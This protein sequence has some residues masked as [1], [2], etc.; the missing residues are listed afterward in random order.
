MISYALAGSQAYGDMLGLSPSILIAPFVAILALLVT[1]FD[2]ILQTVI[3]VMTFVKGSLL[4]VMVAI[5][6]VVGYQVNN[7][8]SDDWLYSGQPFLIGTVALG[9]AVNLL[10]VVYCKIKFTREDMVKFLWAVTLGLLVVF[11][12]NI[13][14]AFY[15]LRIVPQRGEGNTLQEAQEKG[16][17]STIPLV[18]IIRDEHKKYLWA[19]IIVNIFIMVSITVSFITMGTGLKH[20]I[21][22]YIKSWTSKM[23]RVAA[24]PSSATA[25]DCSTKAWLFFSPYCSVRVLQAVLYAGSYALVLGVSMMNPKGFLEVMELAT[26][27]ALNLESG[28]FVAWMMGVARRMAERN[29]EGDIPLPT[30][31]W[32]YAVRWVVMFYFLFAVMYDVVII[33]VAL[34][35]RFL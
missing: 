4:V 29:Q 3:S 25:K 1:F 23:S 27:L 34:V 6:A 10:P 15:V 26:S 8:I 33:G 28:F 18:Q 5:T 21:D 12:L 14:W 22:G 31:G 9:G 16:Q 2:V 30:W 7:A 35:E 32:L 11:L 13:A 17:I 19:A 24:D 20:V